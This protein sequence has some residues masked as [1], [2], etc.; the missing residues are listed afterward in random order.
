MKSSPSLVSWLF[1]EKM[2]HSDRPVGF[3]VRERWTQTRRPQQPVPSKDPCFLFSDPIHSLTWDTIEIHSRA[4][5]MGCDFILDQFRLLHCCHGVC[6]NDGSIYTGLILP[7]YSTTMTLCTIPDRTYPSIA[8]RLITRLPIRTW[9]TRLR[10][11]KGNT[12]GNSSYEMRT[13]ADLMTV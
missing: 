7:F 3:A 4:E 9:L 8:H 10:S 11:H 13:D 6:S 5:N 2:G 1:D 12:T